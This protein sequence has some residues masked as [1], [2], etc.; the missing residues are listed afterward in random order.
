MIELLLWIG[1]LA[2][3][4]GLAA[5]AVAVALRVSGTWHVGG[6]QLGTLLQAGIAAL[7]CGAWAYAASLAERRR[8]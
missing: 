6:L 5:T 1:R 4:L 3:L 8:P 7:A 2:G